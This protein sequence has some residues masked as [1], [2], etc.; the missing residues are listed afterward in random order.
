MSPDVTDNW[1]CFCSFSSSLG[2]HDY[3]YD[4]DFPDK[5]EVDELGFGSSATDAV[6]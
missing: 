4:L 3:E 2:K 6:D 5:D 1:R